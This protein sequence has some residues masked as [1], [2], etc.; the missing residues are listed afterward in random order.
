MAVKF[1]IN[2]FG[3]I[4]RQTLRALLEKMVE[5]KTEGIELVAVNDLTDPKTLAHLLKYDS[6]YGILPNKISWSEK[7]ANKNFDGEIV[8]DDVIIGVISQPDPEKLP[9]KELGV[10]VVIESTGRF[11]DKE[12][13][14]AH[15]RAGAKKVILSAPAKS[16][17]VGTYV[18]GVNMDKI[19]AKEDIISNASCT[20]N[21][22]APVMKII[23]DQFKIKKAMMTTTHA[24]TADQV[25]VDGPHKDLRRARSA[26]INTIPTTTG[27]AIA[28]TKTVPELEGK[29]DG[30]SIRVPVPVGSISDIT[31]V[32]SEEV[33]VAQVNEAIIHACDS[34]AWAGIAT[35]T[36]EPLV[37]S[38]I[39]GNPHSTIVDL[40]LTQVVDKDL[41]KIVAWYDNEWGYS[42]RLVEQ[43]QYLGQL[44]GK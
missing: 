25:L 30:L 24:Y 43:V 31:M 11:T 22:I 28:A 44:M 27:A 17:S 34:Q 23:N 26:A 2:G 5:K 33:T 12:S 1:A 16:G 4:G 42:N 20:T 36:D 6:V 29:F 19:S 38:D 8:I 7:S 40:A 13:C 21:C 35:Y 37:S 39:I 3:R 18:M 10:D 41:V 32:V 15:L 9:W 14:S